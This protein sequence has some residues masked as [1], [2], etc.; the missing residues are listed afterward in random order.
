[1]EFC[2]FAHMKISE[3]TTSAPAAFVTPLQ[4]LIYKRMSE[5]DIP[6]ERVDNEESHTM[7]EA[8]EINEALGMEM[9]KNVFLCNRKRTSFYLFVMRGDRPFVTTEFCKSLGIPR[10]SFAPIESFRELL[11]VDYG[12]AN[13]FCTLADPECRF[14]LV[15]DKALLDREWFGCPDGC[16]TGHIRIKVRDLLDKFLPTIPHKIHIIDIDSLPTS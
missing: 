11:H 5:C 4:E 16:V 12:A 2:N 7:E 8:L 10:V 14:S 3:I 15:I 1:M 6:F 13:I 9:A